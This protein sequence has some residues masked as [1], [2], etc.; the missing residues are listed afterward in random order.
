MSFC[1]QT[2]DSSRF[3]DIYLYLVRNVLKGE[4]EESKNLWLRE[5]EPQCKPPRGFR[6]TLSSVFFPKPCVSSHMI[7]E[8]VEA[9]IQS[10]DYTTDKTVQGCIM[11][12]QSDWIRIDDNICDRARS[13]R[14]KTFCS[15]SFDGER[16]SLKNKVAMDILYYCE[17]ACKTSR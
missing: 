7:K 17:T 1:I 14:Y 11:R 6:E 9:A 5:D 3:R 12:V 15:S 16:N 13:A 4:F 8:M 2:S 10:N